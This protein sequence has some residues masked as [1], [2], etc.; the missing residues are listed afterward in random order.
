MKKINDQ[1]KN[2]IINKWEDYLDGKVAYLPVV[3]PVYSS[4][5]AF[6]KA[7]LDLFD[8][9]KF[10]K[11]VPYDKDRRW[12]VRKREW[13]I[14]SEI[15]INDNLFVPVISFKKHGNSLKIFYYSQKKFNSHTFKKIKK[16]YKK[17]ITK[18]HIKR[19]SIYC[20][21]KPLIKK[22][23]IKQVIFL[24][25][26]TKKDDLNR[27]SKEV[28][29]F[30]KLPLKT[31]KTFINFKKDNS[32]EGFDFLYKKIIN[33]NLSAPTICITQDNKIIGA[34]GPLDIK[35]DAYGRKWLL[36]P[37]FGVTK[38]KRGLGYGQKLWTKAMFFAYNKGARY[39]L[40][41][42]KTNSKAMFFYKKMGLDI[43]AEYYILRVS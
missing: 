8:F 11:M 34:I 7:L 3:G 30:Y 9:S 33:K 12:T 4:N 37:Y 18:Y 21:K 27:T 23:L 15:V 43:G 6:K 24:K 10:K 35:K 19:L 5:K 42:N 36:P 2:L 38:E 29:N 31:R 40:V 25:L 1:L 28:Y 17:I 20:F 22:D 26:I 41:Q 39:T 14:I 32:L 13:I 16:F